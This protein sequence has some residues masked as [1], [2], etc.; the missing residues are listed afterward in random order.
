[1]NKDTPELARTRSPGKRS[2]A[3]DELVRVA[4]ELFSELGYERTTVRLIAERLGVKSGSLYSH[5]SGK[6]QILQEIIVR[7]GEEFVRRA[8]EARLSS[9]DPEIA[10]RQMCREH[11]RILHELQPSVTVYFNEWRKLDETLREDV[12]ALRK[13]YQEMFRDV[14]LA[15]VKAGVFSAPDVRSA[16][17]V[18][19]SSLNWTY[20]WY[21]QHGPLKPD[22]IADGY[23]D[24]VLEGLRAR[25]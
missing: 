15:G 4:N 22:Q 10:L 14:V 18:I 13:Q 8:T 25:A 16:V 11:L 24:F 6:D 12:I 19:L 20:Q 9:E 7:V 17:L 2:A 5:I 23:V 21:D 1:M 3:H